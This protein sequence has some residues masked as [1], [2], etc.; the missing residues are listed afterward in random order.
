MVAHYGGWKAL[1][2]RY[3]RYSSDIVFNLFLC[4]NFK[5][6][7]GSCLLNYEMMVNLHSLKSGD[8]SKISIFQRYHNAI[9]ASPTPCATICRQHH[10]SG[11]L[12]DVLIKNLI[13]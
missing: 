12:R 7:V 13:K 9:D 4:S 1:V 10:K 11:L 3:L 6:F 2:G 5:I 8:Y